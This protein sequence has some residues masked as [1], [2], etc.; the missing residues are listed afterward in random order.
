VGIR[1]IFEALKKVIVFHS[2]SS[3]AKL[4][5]MGIVSSSAADYDIKLRPMG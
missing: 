1:C 2:R 5:E 4:H 3:S